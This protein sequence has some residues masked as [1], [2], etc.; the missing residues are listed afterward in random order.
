MKLSNPEQKSKAVNIVIKL[1]RCNDKY[2][3]KLSDVRT[4]HTGDLKEVQRAQS[5]LSL[6]GMLE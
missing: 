6:S 3:V 5:E 4:K 2:C 1:F